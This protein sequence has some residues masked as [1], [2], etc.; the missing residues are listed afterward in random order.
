[1]VPFNRPW[2]AGKELKYLA[3]A[4]ASDR[5]SGDGQF[6]KRCEAILENLGVARAMLVPSCTHALELSALLLDIQPGDDLISSDVPGHAMLDDIKAFGTSYVV[7]RAAEPVAWSRV[8]ERMISKM[9]L[10]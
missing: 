6:S 9:P 4:L 5:L 2:V 7:A 1:M 3:D 10:I 8:T